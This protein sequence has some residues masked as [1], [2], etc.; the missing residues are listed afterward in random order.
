MVP[1]VLELDL[2][3]QPSASSDRPRTYAEA[4]LQPQAA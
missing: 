2:S 4:S 1:G 3:G